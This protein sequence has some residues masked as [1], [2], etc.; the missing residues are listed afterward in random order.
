MNQLS[1]LEKWI[2]LAEAVPCGSLAGDK[3]IEAFGD[4]EG[5]YEA[6]REKCSAAYPRLRDATLSKLSDKSLDR[7]KEIIGKCAQKGI[8]II[9]R[10]SAEYPERLRNI[11]CAPIVLYARGEMLEVD[12]RAAVAIVGTRD[13]SDYGEKAARLLGREIAEI[14]GIVVSG[15]AKGIDAFAMEGAFSAGGKCIAVLGCGVD[16]AYPRENKELQEKTEKNGTVISEY[17]PG[18]KPDKINFPRRNRII[19]G[20]SLGTVVVEAPEKS[21]AL[22][23]AKYA[24][25]QNRDVFAVP[26]GIFDERS[27]GTNRLIRDGAIPVSSGRDILSEYRHLFGEELRFDESPKERKSE[28]IPKKEEK[29]EEREEKKKEIPA[30]L[31][32]KERAIVSVITDEA[33]L[34]D[35]I[36]QASGLP[37]SA[38]LTHLTMLEIRGT[39]KRLPGSR[40]ILK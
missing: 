31:S 3:L 16:I 4:V 33:R 35:E 10:E 15:L 39:V 29:K 40:F 34:A 37:V 38:V 19:S 12:S 7:A 20:L 36:A 9:T 5:I 8:R 24:L 6:P 21:G 17:P 23:T 14:G 32:E 27:T 2:W 28:I 1:R 18:T 13:A 30:N 22:Y 11:P 25:E 26:S